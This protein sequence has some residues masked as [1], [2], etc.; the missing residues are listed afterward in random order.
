MKKCFICLLFFFAAKGSF[1][2]E[3]VDASIGNG[4][5]PNKVDLFIRNNDV[6]PINAKNCD[7]IVFTIRIPIAG[8]NNVTV[9]ETFKDPAFSHITFV[10]TKYSVNDGNYYYYLINGTGS[11]TPATA[12]I[13]PN[14]VPFRVLEL[15]FTGGTS[16]SVQLVN[17]ENDLP[18]NPLIRPQFYFQLNTGD[19]TD[20]TTMFYGT[21]GATAQNNQAPDGDDWVPTAASVAL[22]VTFSKYNVQCNDKG[23]LVTW[24]TSSEHNSSIF[25]IQRST[26]GIDW[27]VLGSV[28]AAGE[29]DI[30]R[31]YQYLD[32]SGNGQLFYRVKQVDK[33]GRFVYTSI[34]RMTCGGKD[35]DVVV[36]PVP[37]KDVLNVVIKADKAVTTDIQVIDAAGRQVQKIMKNLNSGNN[38]FTLDVSRLPA[39]QYLLTS[40]YPDVQINKKFVVAR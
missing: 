25:E 2:Q 19:V 32:I 35:L 21:A 16:G 30:E 20:Y 29:S 1:A 3:W 31:N 5:S 17:I 23:T 14:G 9:T 12:N 37:A 28:N 33:D 18:P 22:P 34:R 27:E 15:T 13:P 8:G 24:T 26:N 38:S 7:N 6:N 40:S 39:G 36:F 10:I 11:V 4:A